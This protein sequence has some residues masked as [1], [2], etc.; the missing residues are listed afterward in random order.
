MPVDCFG[1][2]VDGEII[3]GITCTWTNL[4]PDG[5]FYAIMLLAVEL[6]LFIRYENYVG[7]AVLG[8][9]FSTMMIVILPPATIMI[10]ILLLAF[11]LGIVIYK[12]VIRT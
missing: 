2:L 7:P 12:S 10:P 11:N 3:T 6:A 8:I 1:L 5:F 9:L 4:L